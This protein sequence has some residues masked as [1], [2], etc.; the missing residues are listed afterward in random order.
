MAIGHWLKN[1]IKWYF[2][3]NC[4]SGGGGDGASEKDVSIA[5]AA[6]EERYINSSAL[7]E[8]LR[9]LA[10]HQNVDSISQNGFYNQ[11]GLESVT[12]NGVK[13]I[14]SGAFSGTIKFLPPKLATRT[15]CVSELSQQ[16]KSK[17]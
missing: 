1:Y 7:G 6:T 2:D 3:P 15:G 13:N 16:S 10:V 4:E 12:L 8:G 5:F 9:E 17:S 11:P 14:N